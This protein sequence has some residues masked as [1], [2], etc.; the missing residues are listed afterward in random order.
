MML[1]ERLPPSPVLPSLMSGFEERLAHFCKT[2][3]THP[4]QAR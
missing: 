3:L 4:L 1:L 2:S